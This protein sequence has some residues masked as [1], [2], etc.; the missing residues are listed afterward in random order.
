MS[1]A[2]TLPAKVPAPVSAP[3]G[4]SALEKFVRDKDWKFYT[5]IVSV[6]LFAGAGLYFLTR[7]SSTTDSD[8]SRSAKA[9]NKKKKSKKRAT[10]K[11]TSTPDEKA[12]GSAA[13]KAK[14]S[15]DNVET[16]SREAIAKLSEK[17]RREHAEILKTR[18]NS[19]YSAK[20]WDD[21]IRLYSQ[22]IAFNPDP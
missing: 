18:G 14:E 22:A 5:A 3:S 11:G 19:M 16:M 1:S 17:Q 4:P 6:S 15:E 9:K 7:S 20:K 8:D 21:A 13:D 2:R 12:E 10:G